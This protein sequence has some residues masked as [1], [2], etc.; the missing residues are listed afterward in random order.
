MLDGRP[1]AVPGLDPMRTAMWVRKLYVACGRRK[2]DE[3][4]VDV[5]YDAFRDAG[6]K[7]EDVARVISTCARECKAMPTIATV[8]ERHY[9][10]RKHAPARGPLIGSG[11]Q[12]A[13]DEAYERERQ[14]IKR[15]F[16]IGESPEKLRRYGPEIKPAEGDRYVPP[17]LRRAMTQPTDPDARESYTGP[18]RAF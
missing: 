9:A 2:P 7:D 16:G 3:D 13:A 4:D 6:L 12:S 1:A 18:R 8:I 11:S 15:N 10:L 5:W 17:S 14:R